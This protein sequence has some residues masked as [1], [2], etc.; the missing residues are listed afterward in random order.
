MPKLTTATFFP[1]K[2]IPFRPSARRPSAHRRLD[3]LVRV[4]HRLAALDL[5]DVLHAFDD[6][7]PHGVLLVEEAGVVEADE[8]LAIRTVRVLRARHRGGAAYMGVRAQLRRQVRIA[9]A[10][11]ARAMRAA[12]LRHEALDHA[13]ERDAVVEA[14]VGKRLDALDMLRREA[15]P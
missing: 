12:G 9:R 4:L 8:A 1:T 7:A 3:D 15:G 10:T 14:F 6:L 5:V 13:V 2:D 11:G